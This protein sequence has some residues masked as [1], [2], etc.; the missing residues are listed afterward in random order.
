[1]VPGTPN[2]GTQS[3]EKVP[4]S[5]FPL[6]WESVGWYW[7]GVPG[8]Q[9]SNSFWFFGPPWADEGTNGK[10]PNEKE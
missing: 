4:Y 1:M 10:V 9:F 3:N 7:E 2:L 8:D 5:A 6:V